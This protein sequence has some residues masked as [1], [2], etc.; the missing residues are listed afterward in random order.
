MLRLISR[1]SSGSCPR[2]RRAARQLAKMPGY[3]SIKVPSRS[4][5]TEQVM[6]RRYLLG[7]GP[8]SHKAVLNHVF[9][10]TREVVVLDSANNRKGSDDGPG[11]GNSR[12]DIVG[13]CRENETHEPTRG[14][15]AKVVPRGNGREAGLCFAGHATMENKN[16]LC[17]S[18]RGQARCESID[19]QR[20]PRAL[21]MPPRGRRRSCRRHRTP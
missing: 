19:R 6:I 9:R 5:R 13:E 16:G 10:S 21:D 15:E 20:K 12:R 18:L 3:E 1:V 14:P 11:D 8:G 4:R 7:N 2:A 17:V